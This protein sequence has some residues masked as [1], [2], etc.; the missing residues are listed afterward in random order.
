[1]AGVVSFAFPHAD[2]PDPVA[3]LNAAVGDLRIGGH[4]GD[5]PEPCVSGILI[6][7]VSVRD[8]LRFHESRRMDRFRA[9]R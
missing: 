4:G 9:V 8:D 5:I 1:M 3:C 2:F 7:A 6:C